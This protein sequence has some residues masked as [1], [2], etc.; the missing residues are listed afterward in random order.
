MKTRTAFT[1]IELIIVLSILVALSGLVLPLCSDNLSV[2]TQ[3][4][5]RSTLVE[6]REA[7]LQYW[8]DTKFVALNGVTTVATEAQRFSLAWLFLNPV[9][10]STAVQ[11]DPNSR[12]GWNGP[13]MAISTADSAALG[14]PNL[15]DG[16]N[17]SLVVQYVSAS[18]SLKDVRIVSA[19]PNGIIDIPL[20]TATSALT[21]SSIGDDL[22]VALMLR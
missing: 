9:T 15:I 13:Y 16:W 22:Y 5:T 18:S 17:Q 1:L 12:S 7:M 3:T 14:G 4:A 6:A 20:S 19:G 21:T 11:F 10:N 8:H 2:A